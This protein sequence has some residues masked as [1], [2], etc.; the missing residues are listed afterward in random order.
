MS[1]FSGFQLILM[2]MGTGGGICQVDFGME[3]IP[4]YG[5]GQIFEDFGVSTIL[6]CKADVF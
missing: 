5:M 1:N 6:L 2:V 3:I 4:T